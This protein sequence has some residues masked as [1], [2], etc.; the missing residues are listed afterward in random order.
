MVFAKECQLLQW[1]SVKVSEYQELL[2]KLGLA[3]PSQGDLDVFSPI[4]GTKLGSLSQNSPDEID[5][6]ANKANQAFK[7]WRAVPAPLRG[8]K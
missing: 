4:D 3:I 6:I 7:E 2:Q 8:E 1:G 5:E